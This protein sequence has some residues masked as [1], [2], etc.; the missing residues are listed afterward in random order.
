MK[1]SACGESGSADMTPQVLPDRLV[2]RDVE[3]VE[4]GAV[5][6]ADQARHLLEV[7]GLEVHHGRGAEAVR[8]LA[9]RD[10]RL[11]EQ[12]AD[13]LAA[14]EAQVAGPRASG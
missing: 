7:L 1:A 9:P 10:Q 8:L 4:L 13:R 3:V 5:V 12:A 2:V 6:V 14:V 11:A